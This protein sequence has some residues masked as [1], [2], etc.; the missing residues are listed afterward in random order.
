M[1]IRNR[2]KF[3]AFCREFAS[4]GVKLMIDTKRVCKNL[5]SRTWTCSKVNKTKKSIV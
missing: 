3:L 5:R 2:K 1:T 4:K